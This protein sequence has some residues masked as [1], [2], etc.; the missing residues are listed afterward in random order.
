M[1]ML[2]TADSASIVAV[3]AGISGFIASANG[4]TSTAISREGQSLYF[5]KYIPVSMKKQLGAKAFSG[6]LLSAV[7]IVLMNAVAVVLGVGILEA[8][9]ALLLGIGITVATSFV[10]LVIDVSKPK[11]SWMNEQQAIKQ[12]VNVMLHMLI[13]TILAA[14]I[15][16]PPLVVGFN[17][18]VTVLY[19]AVMAVGLSVLFWQSISK[20]SVRKLISMDV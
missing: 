17:L 5:A 4:I 9:I 7:G 13:G 14:V 19:V 11:L 15:I 16:I 6:I 1:A 20:G 2:E 10:G 3:M 8:V 12:N 18:I